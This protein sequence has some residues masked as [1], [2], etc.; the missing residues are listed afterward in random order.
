MFVLGD[1]D[2]D[3][4]LRG[5]NGRALLFNTDKIPLKTTRTTQGVNALTSKKDSKLSSVETLEET[6]IKNLKR[7][8]TKNIP[9]AG[10][11]VRPEDLGIEQIGIDLD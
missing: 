7:F 1:D 3:L 2:V 4:I 9:A 6:D 8:K 10:A 5:D 11:L